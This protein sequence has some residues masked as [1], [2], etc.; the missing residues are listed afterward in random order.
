MKAAI[1]KSKRPLPKG[2]QIGL[3]LKAEEKSAWA[4]LPFVGDDHGKLSS[5]WDVP[6]TGGFFG[7]L[8]VGAVIARMFV[9]YL[10]DERDNPL[11]MGESR[12]KAVLRSLELKKASTPE[13]QHSLNG[14][15]TGFIGEL[16][17]WID[18]AVMQ[19]GSS[20]DAIP[21][22]SFIQQV[23]EQLERTDAAFMAAIDWKVSQ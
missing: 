12:L 16:F 13:E 21:Q 8:E 10:R 17:V 19:Q 5:N 20:F 1:P 3:R 18:A 7:G 11:R 23:N 14:Q 15:R 4:R 6:L 9:K 2:K 22:R